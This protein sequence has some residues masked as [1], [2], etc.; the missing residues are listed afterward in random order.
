[1]PDAEKDAPVEYGVDVP[2]P[3]HLDLNNPPLSTCSVCGRSTWSASEAGQTCGMP[4]PSGVTCSGV[5]LPVEGATTRPS[6]AD[7]VIAEVED[8]LR[9]YSHPEDARRIALL[10]IEAYR[11]G[12]ATTRVLPPGVGA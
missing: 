9:S 6:T 2:M 3:Y 8:R 7:D 4:Q 5:F 12:R 11:E 1:M 10:H